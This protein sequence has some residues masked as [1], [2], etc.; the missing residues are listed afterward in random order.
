M[1]DGFSNRLL[2]CTTHTAK[3]LGVLSFVLSKFWRRGRW[4][5]G[6][7]IKLFEFFATICDNVAHPS[8]EVRD[9]IPAIF[10]QFGAHF[11][12][13]VLLFHRFDLWVWVVFS[14]FSSLCRG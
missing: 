7:C 3:G 2:W 11:V 4:K 1:G 6:I 14:I 12:P 13:G 10:R 9:E 5:R 8:S